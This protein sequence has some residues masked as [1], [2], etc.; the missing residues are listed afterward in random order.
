MTKRTMPWTLAA[1]DLWK[2]LPFFGGV[3]F[4][5]ALIQWVGY[6][7]FDK[8]N[9]GSELL[10]EHIAYYSLGLLII[11][12][13]PLKAIVWWFGTKRECPGAEQFVAHLAARAVAFASV[14]TA[15]LVG[16][17]GGAAAVGKWGS[18]SQFL[19]ISLYFAALA[20]IA[21]NRSVLGDSRMYL[22]AIGVVVGI[23]L[24]A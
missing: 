15:V 12:L 24:S 4:V 13:W 10:Q 22:P 19:Y 11:L 2:D 3:G 21:A 6:R 14:A 18:A 17:A 5:C 16:F 1:K 23:T 20:E 9:V 7:H 8:A